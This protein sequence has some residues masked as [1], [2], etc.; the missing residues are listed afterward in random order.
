[1]IIKPAGNWSCVVLWDRKD[2]LVETAKQ[3][4]DA[5]IYEYSDF[6]ETDLVNLLEKSNTMFQSL[7][8]KKL[9][10]E[11]ELRYPSLQYKSQIILVK[12]ISFSK[13]IRDWR[14]NRRSSYFKL[15]NTN[16]KSF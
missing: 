4:H 5:D 15:W 11:K 3:H 1:M 7:K 14:I 9:I 10:I 2:Y 16:R 12:R 8:R 13:S 6:K